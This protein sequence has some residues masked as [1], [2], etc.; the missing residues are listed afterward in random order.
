MRNVENLVS[1]KKDLAAINRKNFKLSMIDNDFANLA[2][3]LDLSED[4]LMKYTSK[5]EHTVC[6]LKNCKNCKGLRRKQVPNGS[7]ANEVKRC[8]SRL[9][10]QPPPAKAAEGA[11]CEKESGATSHRSPRTTSVR[12]RVYKDVRYT[13]SDISKRTTLWHSSAYTYK[14]W[15][16]HMLCHPN[17][18]I[19][20]L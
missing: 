18:L 12:I 8:R 1:S 16:N 11:L 3:K 5:L 2:Y 6:E 17:K 20:Q 10:A 9:Q 19:Y 13:L 4:I 7:P 14:K 15:Q